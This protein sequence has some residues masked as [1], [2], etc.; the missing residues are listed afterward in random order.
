MILS[1]QH[2]QFGNQKDVVNLF[3]KHIFFILQYYTMKKFDSIESNFSRL[4]LYSRN[5]NLS[6]DIGRKGNQLSI[7]I[8]ERYYAN[9]Q[10]VNSVG[11]AVESRCSTISC[12]TTCLQRKV[13]AHRRWDG[14]LRRRAVNTVL[15]LKRRS[16]YG[17][18]SVPR[19]HYNRDTP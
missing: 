15:I 6:D 11:N 13:F 7:I 4:L 16:N 17:D 12:P 14:G 2:D 1:I 5:N 9:D 3:K 10:N 19:S 18:L 8:A